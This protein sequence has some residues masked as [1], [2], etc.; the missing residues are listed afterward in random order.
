MSSFAI[1]CKKADAGYAG[2]AKPAEATS[3]NAV[4]ET[5]KETTDAA[6]AVKETVK[7]EIKPIER[8]AASKAE[9]SDVSLELDGANNEKPCI[10]GNTITLLLANSGEEVISIVD[11][12]IKG[13]NGEI[14]AS[15]SGISAG[16]ASTQI[17]MYGTERYGSLEELTLIPVIELG[18]GKKA[19]C[20]DKAIA[21]KSIGRC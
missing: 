20:E 13:S 10:Y 12:H 14:A 11:M 8:T 1:G 5:T 16:S 18:N 3:G 9:C 6:N 4:K 21:E 2:D 15:L 17:I 19:A 7:S